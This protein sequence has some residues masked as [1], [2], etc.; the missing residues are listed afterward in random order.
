MSFWEYFFTA[1]ALLL[2]VEG[3]M[4]SVSPRAWRN[5]MVR[6]SQQPDASLRIMGLVSMVFGALIMYLLHSGVL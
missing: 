1:L 3:I 2:V 6:L 5:M 4:P